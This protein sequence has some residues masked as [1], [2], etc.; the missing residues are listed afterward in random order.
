MCRWYRDS[1]GGGGGGLSEVGGKMGGGKCAC[2]DPHG[3][4]WDR[5]RFLYPNFSL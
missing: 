2:L 1:C 5:K 4:S 3:L